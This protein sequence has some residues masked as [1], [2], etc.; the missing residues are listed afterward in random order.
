MGQIDAL[1]DDEKTL[2]EIILMN[3]AHAAVRRK[4]LEF[5]KSQIPATA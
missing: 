3:R 4:C 5:P 1:Y 2:M